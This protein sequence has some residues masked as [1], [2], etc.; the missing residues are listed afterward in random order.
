MRE[1]SHNHITTEKTSEVS[2]LLKFHENF[3][4]V[5]RQMPKHLTVN[6]QKCKPILAVKCLRTKRLVKQASNTSSGNESGCN[7]PNQ[8]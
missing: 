2:K 8:T 4:G 7:Y 3:D 1:F 6:R 5:N